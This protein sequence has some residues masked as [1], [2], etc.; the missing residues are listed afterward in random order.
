MI[1]RIWA[2]YDLSR[3]I[4]CSHLILFFLE[5]V[6]FILDNAVT[7]DPAVGVF[8]LH[9]ATNWTKVA[10]TLQVIN[11]A[12]VCIFTIIQ[13]AKESFQMYRVTR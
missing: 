4:F 10:A 6:S 2:M 7:S 3:L 12:T 9:S 1:L 8:I 13:F 11:G 5:I